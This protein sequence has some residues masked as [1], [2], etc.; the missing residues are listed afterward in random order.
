MP[1]SAYLLL[2]RLSRARITYLVAL[3]IAIVAPY[4]YWGQLQYAA[5][6]MVVVGC[7]VGIYMAQ[8]QF[9]VTLPLTRR[10]RGTR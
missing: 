4:L 7:S 8:N 3:S 9:N 5:I 6:D 10:S 2:K 1:V